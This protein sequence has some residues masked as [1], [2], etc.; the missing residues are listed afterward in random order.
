MTNSGVSTHG[1]LSQTC[2]DY[3]LVGNYRK[4]NRLS[5]RFSMA[6]EKVIL[7]GFITSHSTVFILPVLGNPDSSVT[8]SRIQG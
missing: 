2:A 3:A 8:I 7:A 1:L 6:A 4:Y 5:L